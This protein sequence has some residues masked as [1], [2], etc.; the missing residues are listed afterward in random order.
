[1]EGAEHEL[2]QGKQDES[3]PEEEKKSNDNS[4]VA[5]VTE[6]QQY[7]DIVIPLDLLED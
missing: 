5:S 6:V 4:K 1:L 2:G 7:E 3:R